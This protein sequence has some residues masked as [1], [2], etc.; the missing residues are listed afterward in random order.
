MIFADLSIKKKLIL[1]PLLAAF[2]VL[3]LAS[4]FNV[5]NNAGANRAAIRTKL[6][7]LTGMLGYNCTSALVFRDPG[8][9]VKTL[10]SLA[11]E[12]NVIRAWILDG[13]GRIFA[14]YGKP[15]REVLSPA[16]RPGDFE[17]R[18]SR[19]WTLSRRIVQDGEEIGTA[20]LTYDLGAY[21]RTIFR[22]YL[23]AGAALAIG[24]LIAW[25]LAFFAQ[26]TL[27]VPI[28]RLVDVIGHVSRTND[29]SVR[30]PEPR[31]DEIGVLYR[32]FNAMLAMIHNREKDRDQA[33][34]ALRESES[35]YRTLVEN[36]KDG[37]VIIQDDRFV[38]ANQSLVE[39]SESPLE[40]LIG[41]PFLQH[42]AAEER[43]K[44]AFFYQNR[45]QGIVSASIYET[46][47]MTKSGR[48]IHAEVNAAV[49]PYRGRPADLVII[50]DITERKKIEA[51]IRALNE[52][53][54]RRVEERTSELAA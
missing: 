26:R 21:R 44:L 4:G 37:I 51:E 9:A 17:A 25:I 40:E 24:M 36:A 16:A 31:K 22:S 6:I 49:I 13:A 5:L 27:S 33:E 50:R 10:Q 28:L 42:V 12:P 1:L 23:L 2:T 15:A 18:Q 29:L 45:L 52:S 48:R 8:D 54:E 3:V 46:I 19:T 20:G 7:S 39:M 30:I 43:E 14:E 35:K 47:F 32:G 11:A 41:T 34:E 53:L 38:F